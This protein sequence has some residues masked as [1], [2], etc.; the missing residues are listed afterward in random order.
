MLRWARVM[1]T[2]GAWSQAEH[3]EIPERLLLARVHDLLGA[4]E[5]D[6]VAANRRRAQATIR[7]VCGF[8]AVFSELELLGLLAD[9]PTDPDGALD[10]GRFSEVV[11]AEVQARA[12]TDR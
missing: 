5:A 9:L 3:L 2:F 11:A 6:L 1:S 10:V 7:A 4:A 8:R 12:Q